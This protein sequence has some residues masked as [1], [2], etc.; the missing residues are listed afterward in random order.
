LVDVFLVRDACLFVVW[1]CALLYG[2]SVDSHDVCLDVVRIYRSTSRR[3]DCDWRNCLV[4]SVNFT[5]RTVK[6][7]TACL[8]LVADDS[9]LRSAQ[10]GT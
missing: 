6:F 3:A 4:A 5:V 9:G 2:W 10:D 1:S 7:P 8:Q